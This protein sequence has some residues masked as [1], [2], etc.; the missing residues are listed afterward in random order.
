MPSRG[1]SKKIEESSIFIQLFYAVVKSFKRGYMIIGIGTDLIEIKR[2]DH[3]LARWHE[4]ALQRLFTAYEIQKGL[5]ISAP[6]RYF[7]KRFAAKEALVKA[8]GLGFRQKI[9]FQDIEVGNDTLGKPCLSLQGM[10]AQKLA[11]QI[12]PNFQPQIHVTL[13]DTQDHALAFV[14]IEQKRQALDVSYDC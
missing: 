8:L 2:I 12:L 10:A 7:A 9:T 4:R 1:Y 11:Q 13:S 6:S 14:V 5:N 3:L